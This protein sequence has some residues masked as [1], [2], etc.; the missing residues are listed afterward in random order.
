MNFIDYPNSAVYKLRVIFR[1]E[2]YE[3]CINQVEE[4][5]TTRS[6]V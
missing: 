2:F 5:L 6:R 1:I 3:S 4:F